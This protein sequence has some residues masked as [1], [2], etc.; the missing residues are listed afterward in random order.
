ME[1]VALPLELDGVRVK[2]ARAAALEA[3]ER[4]DLAERADRFP[5]RAVRR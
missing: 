4:L 2:A 3:L 5:G 1:N